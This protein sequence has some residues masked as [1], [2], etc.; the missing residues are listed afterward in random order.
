MAGFVEEL[1]AAG[2]LVHE[3]SEHVFRLAEPIEALHRDVAEVAF[4]TE[5]TPD[6]CARALGDGA[7]TSDSFATWLEERC[8][9]RRSANA[10]AATVE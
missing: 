4:D 6:S 1:R 10:L 5:G 3:S 7:D 9:D 2:V 8:R